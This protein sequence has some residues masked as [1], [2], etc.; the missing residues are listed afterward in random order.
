VIQGQS[1]MSMLPT[2]S[3][4][5][6]ADENKTRVDLE[7]SMKISGMFKLMEFMLPSQ[8]KKIWSNYFIQLNEL[9]S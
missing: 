3:F 6:N 8:L 4:T 2:Q 7:V 1:G 5:F 9:A